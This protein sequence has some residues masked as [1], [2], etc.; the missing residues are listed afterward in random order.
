M[1]FL[2]IV[3]DNKTSTYFELREMQRRYYLYY[4][5]YKIGELINGEQSL[6]KYYKGDIQLWINKLRTRDINR[7][8]KISQQI[9][10]LKKE[11]KILLNR[12]SLFQKE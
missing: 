1:E 4:S 12:W 11:E 10:N 9:I 8:S 7:I 5:G 6:K 3:F 2:K